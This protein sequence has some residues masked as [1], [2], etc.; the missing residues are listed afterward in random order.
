[1]KRLVKVIEQYYYLNYSIP[2]IARFAKVSEKTVDRDLKRAR[3]TLQRI[4][5]ELPSPDRYG[6]AR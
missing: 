3:I 6:T 1:M 2:D 5:K 4:M